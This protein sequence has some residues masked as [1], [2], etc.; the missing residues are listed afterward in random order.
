MKKRATAS[1]AVALFFYEKQR[2]E[3][4]EQN[5]GVRSQEPEY[6]AETT[7][8]DSAFFYSVS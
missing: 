7:L 4:R 5:S 6:K 3:A 2:T 1:M 8:T